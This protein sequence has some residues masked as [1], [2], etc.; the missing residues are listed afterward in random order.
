MVRSILRVPE[1]KLHSLKG[2]PFLSTYEKNILEDMLVI[3][4]PL[5]EAT[6]CA[7]RQNSVS[8][9]LIIPCVLGLKFHLEE[10]QSKYNSALIS[11]L[12][13]SVKKRLEMYENI[14]TLQLSTILDP[15]FKMDWCSDDGK[16]ENMKSSMLTTAH[17]MTQNLTTSSYSRSKATK[18]SDGNL[19]MAEITQPKRKKLFSFMNFTSNASQRL[20]QESVTDELRRYLAQPCLSEETDVMPYWM[21]HMSSFPTLAK[22]AR[23][24]LAA[25]ASS[26]PVERMF[27]IAGKVFRPD[28]CRLTDNNFETVMFI[29]CNDKKYK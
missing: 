24:Y 4:E 6:D 5:E 28:R 7:Q 23:K 13:K 29:K 10:I 27:S 15:R 14:K 22:M 2:V 26:A 1:E 12:Q 8:S 17:F 21:V 19:C 3:L 16:K 18:Y 20:G 9:S 25:A 11:G